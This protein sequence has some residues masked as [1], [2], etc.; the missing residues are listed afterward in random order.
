MYKHALKGG[1]RTAKQA[2]KLKNAARITQSCAPPANNRP[3]LLLKT[4]GDNSKSSSHNSSSTAA[5]SIVANHYRTAVNPRSVLDKTV[6]PVFRAE[7]CHL[8]AL[9]P[10][11]QFVKVQKQFYRDFS[12]VSL[13]SSL[14]NSDAPLLGD[15]CSQYRAILA[16]TSADV[17]PGEDRHRAQCNYQQK[18][19]SHQHNHSREEQLEQEKMA[20][21]AQ[22][23]RL[24]TNVVPR[25]YELLLQ[26]DLEEFTFTGKTVVQ[27]QVK[28]PT[29][30]ITLNALDITIDSVELDYECTKLKPEKIV[31]SVE[32]ETATLEFGKEIPNDTAGVLRMSFTGELNDKMKGFYRSKYFGPNGEERYAGVTQFEAT[33]ARRCFPCWD[34]PAIKATFD[35]TLVVPKDRVALSNMPVMKEDALPDGL[36]RVRFD[37][38]PIMSTYLVAVVVG[39]YDYVEGKSD[40]G[41]IVRVFTPV[42]KR[43]Q[44]TF[45]LEVATKVLPYYKDY[46][47]IAYPLPKMDLIAISD[48][49]AGAMENWGL[50]T[51]RETFVLVDPKNTSLMR[52][53]SIALTVGHEIAHQWF[54]NLVTMEWWTHLWLNEGYASFVEFLCVHHLFPEYDIWTQFVTDMY[55]RALELD[56]LKNSH[57]IEVPV[58]HPSEIDEIFDEISYNKG[59]SVIRMLHDYIGEDDFRKGM[60]LYLTRH[61]YGN[62]CTEDL[63]TALQEA[64]SKKVADVM[65]SWTQHKGFPVVSVEQEQQGPKK[66]VLRLKQCKFT[67]DGSEAE[68]DCLWTVPISVSTSKN[69]TGI[70]KTFLLDK[71]SME[72]VLENVEE[73]DWIKINPGT[74]GYYRTRYSSDMLE[75]LMPAVAR[76]EL[77]PL[78]RLGLIDDMFAM[79]QAG[80]AST[81]D[82]LALVDAYRNETNY[83]VWTAITNSLTNLHILISHT[84]LMDHFHRFGRN[85]YEPVAQRLGWEPRDGENHLDTLLRSLVLTRLV[86]FRSDEVIDSARARFRSHV[87]GTNPLPAD[88]R[89]TCYKAVL[90]DGDE[91]VFE[92]ML[93]LYRNTDLHEEQDRISRALG[94]CSDV[95]LLRRVIDFAMSGEVRAQ[96][97]VFVIVAVAINPKGR[98]MAWE[99]FKENNKQ[100]LERYQGGFLLSRLIKYLIENFAT[101]E[102]AREVEEFFKANHI[103]GCER[104]VS[105]AVETIRLNAA[106]LKRDKLALSA[107]LEQN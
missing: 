20:Q 38:T 67:A 93:N 62:T 47:N 92:E 56:S 40:D 7:S 31:Y 57:P 13:G 87:T 30:Q 97:S 1:I 28:E 74:V 55:T 104:T 45:A 27:V 71:P 107:F 86:S 84:D 11:K 95:K 33:D 72:V 82:V 2:W 63:W 46:F 59:A 18:R 69:P 12:S 14:K 103:P 75:Q 64:S 85:L 22:F 39:E 91:K 15:L 9:I 81:A 49:S 106:W 94:C 66:R 23:E 70:A 88:L 25:H 19:R 101:E 50:V 99:F 61:Q 68:E 98:D 44:G 16:H 24:P 41:V 17:V 29:S 90:Q 79:V 76:M 73:N 34:E 54:G 32:N 78:D 42:G 58:G 26:P 35:I 89:T 8:N 77:P 6:K 51:Y 83:T 53:Q 48:F 60:N 5:C 3:L 43:E 96:D 10:S 37:R 36:R 100:L 102:R 105:Q 65:S 52:K 80:H 4:Q 21:K